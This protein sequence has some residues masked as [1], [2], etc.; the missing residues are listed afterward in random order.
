MYKVLYVTPIPAPFQIELVENSNFLSKEGEIKLLFLNNSTDD[1][2]IGEV[3]KKNKFLNF[4]RIL[5]REKPDLVIFGNYKSILILILIFRK[6]FFRKKYIL[7]PLEI[8]QPN[9][10]IFFHIKSIVFKINSNFSDGILAVGNT[11]CKFYEKLYKYSVINIPYSFNLEHL[12][13]K[14]REKLPN[15]NITFLFSG[16]LE[17]FRNPIGAINVFHKVCEMYPKRDFNLII[18]GKGS[19]EQNCLDEINIL[20]IKENVIW[21]NDFKNW[22][23]IHTI[24][25]LSDVLLAV[26]NYSGWG[27]I[28]QEAMSARMG[29]IASN[30]MMSA[31]DLIENGV[32]GYLIDPKNETEILEAM[33]KYIENPDLIIEHGNSSKSSVINVDVKNVSKKLN[34]FIYNTV[35]NA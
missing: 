5:V 35:L 9:G 2:K 8:F 32:N 23:D 19:L 31:K 25:F 14:K 24:Y 4:Y 16:R 22:Y 13:S 29:I 11:A 17:S 33:K 20:G 30:K 7:G 18:S 27:I 28:I 21:K 34:N 12:I 6:F 10:K 26:Q 15:K 1:K 3:L